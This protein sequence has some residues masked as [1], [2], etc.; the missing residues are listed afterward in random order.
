MGMEHLYSS[1][2]SR[3]VIHF[4]QD[5]KASLPY[6]GP[7]V[8]GWIGTKLYG[9][10]HLFKEVF[11]PEITDVKPYFLYT[12]HEGKHIWATLSFLGEPKSFMAEVSKTLSSEFVTNLGGI[13]ARIENIS[14]SLEEFMG[15]EVEKEVRVRFISPTYMEKYGNPQ[16]A[17]SFEDIVDAT[18]RSANRYMKFFAPEIYPLRIRKKY[19]EDIIKSFSVE[20]FTWEHHRRNGGTVPLSGTVGEIV[21]ELK[22]EPNRDLRRILG[23][24][25]FFQIGKRVGYGFGKVEVTA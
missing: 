2:Y 25:S 21:Y 11:K 4:I 24:T 14:Y 20:T 23:L 7:I 8:R 12:Q 10:K 6:Y 5:R 18:L 3:F 13:P 22:E 9:N 17:P 1:T 15:V 19:I 16:I